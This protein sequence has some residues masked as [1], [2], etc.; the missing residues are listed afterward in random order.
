MKTITN[1]ILAIGVVLVAVTASHA[2][3]TFTKIT[4]G[5][6]VN[7]LGVFTRPVWA[8]FNN[9]GFLDLFVSGF[10]DRI[11]VFYLNNGDG[12]FTKRTQGDPVQDVDFHSGCVAGDIDNDG[13]IDLLVSA[14]V[15]ASN[16]RRNKLYHNMGNAMFNQVS[17]GAITN[18]LGYFDA[19]AWADYDKD[20]FLDLVITDDPSNGGGRTWLFHNNGD[21]TFTRLPSTSLPES[22]AGGGVL[23][24]DYDNDGYVDLT[25]VNAVANGRNFLYHN[26]RNG[27]FTRITTNAI[28]TDVWL[29]GATSGAW[30]DFDNDGLPDL[31]IVGNNTANRLYHNEGNGRFTSITSGPMLQL[32][33]GGAVWGDYDNDGYLDL[34]VTCYDGQNGLFHNNGDG[35]FTEV[36]SEPPVNDLHCASSAFVDY[37]NDGFLDLFL[38]RAL[39]DGSLVSNSL[40]HNNGNTNSWLEVKLVGT[41]ANRSGIGAKVRVKATINGKTFWQM[42]E[43]NNGGG[44]TIQPL[45]AHFG[46]G[47]ATNIETLRIEWPSDTVQEIQNVAPKQILTIT[48]PSRLKPLSSNGVPQLILQGGR[49]LQYDIQTSTNLTVWSVLS[50]L[51]ITNLNGTALVTDTNPPVSDRRFYRAVLR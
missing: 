10:V 47:N 42:R 32:G 38:T 30:G 21:A 15:I 26:N 25:V 22:S 50:T 27:T 14:G 3:T 34:F 39:F 49:N 40:Y 18:Q 17:G 46:L 37:D 36:D 9:D 12:T 4:T 11:N 33:N 28:A 24:S 31:F 2:Q 35:T 20:G 44:W 29:S 6:V 8:D 48:E 7:D 16:P 45:V 23:W 43:I 13:Q 19:C 1:S 51:T 41:V 5:P